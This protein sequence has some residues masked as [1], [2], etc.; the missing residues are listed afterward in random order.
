MP[1]SNL[2]IFHLMHTHWEICTHF[3]INCHVQQTVHSVRTCRQLEL[4]RLEKNQFLRIK[5]IKKLKKIQK[6]LKNT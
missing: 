4:F 5:I 1:F 3:Y 2:N 6:K